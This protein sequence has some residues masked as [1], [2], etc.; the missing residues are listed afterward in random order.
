[1]PGAFGAH[2]QVAR[3]RLV[4]L[5]NK[6]VLP[7]LMAA[8]LLRVGEQVDA[9]LAADA[10]AFH[11]DV[12]DAHFVP[13]LTLGSDFTRALAGP[14]RAAGGVVDVHLMVE[15]PAAM[16]EA[17][18]PAADAISI[19]LEADPHPHRLLGMIRET[20][21]LAGLALN[22][23]TPVEAIEPLIESVDFVNLLA[24][25]PGF[26]GQSF[27]TTAPERVATAR[28][29]VPDRVAIQI[30]GGVDLTSLPSVRDAGANLF[31]AGSAVFGA[32]D[33]VV[34]YRDLAALA[35]A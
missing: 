28:G 23:G 32:P 18:A 35:R 16:I 26:A 17:F 7:S 19:H 12:M 10:R 31:V 3:F 29:L 6:T 5:G 8:D 21:A 22:P 4:K 34:A 2:G 15:S 9:L 13:N 20:G 33:P 14:V 11:V 27:I 1:M 30:D 25:N 24:V